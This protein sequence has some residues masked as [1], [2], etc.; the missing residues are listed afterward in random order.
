ML[1]IIYLLAL[2]EGLIRLTS[3]VVF[4]LILV[5]LTIMGIIEAVIYFSFMLTSLLSLYRKILTTGMIQYKQR[6]T[7]FSVPIAFLFRSNKVSY[8]ERYLWSAT[9]KTSL[10][11]VTDYFKL[12]KTS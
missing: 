4:L 8:T 11:L 9:K 7:S 10:S 3:F 12:A 6:L 5:P 1:P 2:I